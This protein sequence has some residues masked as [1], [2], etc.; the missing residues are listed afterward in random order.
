MGQEV[1]GTNNYKID[2]LFGF[3]PRGGGAFRL[4]RDP[5]VLPGAVRIRASP[6]SEASLV[7]A[8][9]AFLTSE[10]LSAMYMRLVHVKSVVVQTS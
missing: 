8:S 2:S 6:T 10:K 3:S 9:D 7:L 5:E 4:E 1:S